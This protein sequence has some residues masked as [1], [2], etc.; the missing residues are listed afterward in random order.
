MLLLA[1]VRD[2]FGVTWLLL[3]ATEPTPIPA[4]IGHL[5]YPDTAADANPA[6]LAKI[7]EMTKVVIADFE[8]VD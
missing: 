6:N 1:S 8:P 3:L 7:G 2:R 4:L 5:Y